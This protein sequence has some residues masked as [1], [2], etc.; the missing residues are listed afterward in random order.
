MNKTEITELERDK[1]DLFSVAL[2]AT[3]KKKNAGSFSF[4][5]LFS[6]ELVSVLL[7]A[8]EWKA[9]S[10]LAHW[11]ITKSW[12]R[13]YLVE[14]ELG[15]NCISGCI[16]KRLDRVRINSSLRDVKSFYQKT[17]LFC[18]QIQ[19]IDQKICDANV[20]DSLGH[21]D[22][23]AVCALWNVSIAAPYKTPS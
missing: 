20:I 4:L 9:E 8:Q 14:A 13:V 18:A 21:S 12:T 2:T 6:S 23:C 15:I 16:E 19:K 10:T 11:K 17:Q 1:N 5:T 7:T 22:S 3:S